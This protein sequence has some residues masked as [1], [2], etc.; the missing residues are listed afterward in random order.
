M[1]LADDSYLCKGGGSTFGVLINATLQAYPIPMVTPAFLVINSTASEASQNSN[2]NF[3]SAVAYLHAQLPSLSAD[4]LMG[5]YSMTSVPGSNSSLPMYFDFLIYT[6][7]SSPLALEAPLKLVMDN[8]SS[9]AGI[10]SLL[11]VRPTVDFT[12]FR[13]TYLTAATVGYNYLGGNRLWDAKAVG[14]S[15]AIAKALKAFEKGYLEGT[16]ESGPGV[17]VVAA[18]QSSVNPAWRQTVLEVSE[19]TSAPRPFV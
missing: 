3:F 18:N 15:K 16:F 1:S 14:D 10:T 12:A 9:I 7:S 6:L 13:A 17:Q 8:L 4:G 2:T 19:Y 11:D 5:Y